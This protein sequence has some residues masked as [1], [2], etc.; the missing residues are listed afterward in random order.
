[1]ARQLLLN[2]VRRVKRVRWVL[3]LLWSGCIS[4]SVAA[5]LRCIKSARLDPGQCLILGNFKAS[6]MHRSCGKNIPKK[7]ASTVTFGSRPPVLLLTACCLIPPQLSALTSLIHQYVQRRRICR[8][9]N[10]IDARLTTRSRR[11]VFLLRTPSWRY[12]KSPLTCRYL[13]G[14]ETDLSNY[15]T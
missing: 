14:E 1:M 9:S 6:C 8:G 5:L 12:H 10:A 11:S 7:P 4:K 3:T 15:S 2:L 13:H